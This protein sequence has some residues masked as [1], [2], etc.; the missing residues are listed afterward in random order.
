MF[1]ASTSAESATLPFEISVNKQ[2]QSA[3]NIS[4][5]GSIPKPS[6]AFGFNFRPITHFKKYVNNI[7]PVN[8]QQSTCIMKLRPNVSFM[9]HRVPAQTYYLD[10]SQKRDCLAS[11]NHSTSKAVHQSFENSTIKPIQVIKNWPRTTSQ[12]RII[13]HSGSITP[14]APYS[15]FWIDKG[16]GIT[17]QPSTPVQHHPLNFPYFYQPA[18]QTKLIS[19]PHRIQQI[20]VA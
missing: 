16:Y 18:A 5:Q 6:T 3:E 2:N 1:Q 14:N 19:N 10:S 11:A 13:F 4:T 12:E 17:T 15:S 20:P 7:N 9:E 8:N